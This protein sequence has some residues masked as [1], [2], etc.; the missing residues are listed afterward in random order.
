MSEDPGRPLKRILLKL[1]GEALLGDEDYGIDPKVLRRIAGEIRDVMT[2]GIE[3]AVVIG[4]GNLFRGAGLA[5]AGMDRV[6]ADHMGMLATVMNALALQD[7]LEQLGADSRVMSALRVQQVCE[8]YIRRRAIRH[9]EK[10]RCVIMA[11]GTGNPFFTTDT[12]ASLRAIE[13]E[14]DLLLKATKVNGV[15]DDDPVRNPKAERYARLSFDKVL[16]DRLGVMDAT[17]IVMC[18]DNDLPL[19]VFN[20]FNAGD[21]IRIVDGEDVGTLVAN[22]L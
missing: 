21:L 13:I 12:A 10:G 9:L 8:D 14:A 7:A 1:S 6:T 19:R 16:A 20:L 4:G 5:R 22:G 18:R 17:A 11:A 15:Y 3:V 2:R